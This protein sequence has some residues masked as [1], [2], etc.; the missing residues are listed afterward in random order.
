MNKEEKSALIRFLLIYTLSSTFFM[1]II[2]FMYFEREV[3]M[4][5]D[6]CSMKTSQAAW[7][8]KSE[9]LEAHMKHIPYHFT[10]ENEVL[11][12]AILKNDNSVFYSDLKFPLDDIDLTKSAHHFENRSLHVLNLSD[13]HIEYKYI[14]VEDTSG[15][16]EINRLKYWVVFLFIMGFFIMA[17]FGYVLS[18]ILLKPVKEK[19]EKLNRF[20]KDSSHELNTP[21][22]ALMMIVPALKKRYDIEEKTINQMIASAKNIKQT[23]EKLLFNING[24]IVKRYDEQFDLKELIEQ[25]V[26]FFDEIA[27]SKLITLHTNLQSCNI[28]MDRYSANMVVNNLLSNALKYTRKRKNIY[29]ELNDFHLIVR[30]EG[31]GIDKHMQQEVFKRYRRATNEEGGFGIGLDVVST[32]CKDYAIEIGIFSEIDVGT[33]FK[34]DFTQVKSNKTQAK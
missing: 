4:F 22:T 24:D 19:A 10:H 32:V 14:I 23:Y 25:N 2:A 31:I 28:V 30:D 18:R 21:I 17:C 9:I 20:V 5:E 13:Q 15:V 6:Q 11:N 7:K 29:I 33:E 3:T 16:N 1:L 12:Y 26:L 8:V 27:K 34:L